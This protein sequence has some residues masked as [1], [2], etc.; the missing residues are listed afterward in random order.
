MRRFGTILSVALLSFGLAVPL[1]A[2]SRNTAMQRA[3]AQASA[4]TVLDRLWHNLRSLWAASGS[5]I[6][7]FGKPGQAGTTPA[8]PPTTS[9]DAGSS[10]DPFGAH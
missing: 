5:S 1:A 4:P 6:D 7:P 2:A 9:S 8:P 10:I 3:G